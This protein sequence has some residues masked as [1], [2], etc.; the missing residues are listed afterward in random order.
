LKLFLSMVS[1]IIKR[2]DKRGRPLLLTSPPLDLT[3]EVAQEI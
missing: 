3:K 1:A 2:N